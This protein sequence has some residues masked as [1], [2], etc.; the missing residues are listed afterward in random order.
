MAAYMESLKDKKK[1]IDYMLLMIKPISV[2]LSLRKSDNT[3]KCKHAHH[4]SV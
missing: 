3:S 4:T 1:K 2:K